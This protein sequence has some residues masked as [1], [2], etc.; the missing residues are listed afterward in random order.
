MYA[1][2]LLILSLTIAVIYIISLSLKL[3]KKNLTLNNLHTE[4]SNYSCSIQTS[5]NLHH[6]ALKELETKNEDNVK[7][8]NKI[9]EELEV[10]RKEELSKTQQRI[11]E[12][13]S[14][15]ASLLN[16][17]NEIRERQLRITNLKT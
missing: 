1:I 17:D 8:Y 7:S 9:F 13:E 16:L 12:L 14:T 11:V 5:D 2:P 15:Y 10:N 6:A 4:V 3:K